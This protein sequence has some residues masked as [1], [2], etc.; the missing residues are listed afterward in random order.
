M[1][2]FGM[3]DDKKSLLIQEVYQRPV[4]W[5]VTDPRYT[6][7]PS[8][9]AAYAEIADAL[10]D[11]EDCGYYAPLSED[12]IPAPIPIRPLTTSRMRQS[13]LRTKTKRSGR[14]SQREPCKSTK[15]LKRT[16]AK[17]AAVDRSFETSQRRR[18]GKSTRG[19]SF[20]EVEELKPERVQFV[21]RT[22]RRSIRRRL[23]LSPPPSRTPMKSPLKKRTASASPQKPCS[24]IALANQKPLSTGD[25][26][27]AF[28]RNMAARLLLIKFES[29][30]TYTRVCQS[31]DESLRD[32]ETLLDIK[33]AH[34]S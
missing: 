25:P 27:T 7:V 1:A 11:D 9:W 18:G 5:K 10:S 4:L 23:S 34:T 30:T 28:A 26:V 16:S 6:D 19:K 17:S 8:R 3:K 13:R 32:V 22:G 33:I 2:M 29:L 12:V 15:P 31:I 20:V 24:H 21:T 14:S